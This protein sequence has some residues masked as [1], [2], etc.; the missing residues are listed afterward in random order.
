MTDSQSPAVPEFDLADRMRKS[1]RTSGTSV[2]AMA[3]HLDVSRETVST[4]IN[5]RHAPSTA[6]LRVWAEHTGVPYEW[7]R[8][9]RIRAA[10]PAVASHPHRRRTDRHLA[11]AS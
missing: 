8:W 5:G 7:L 4:W 2:Q 3:T 10:V 11:V 9:G 6:A 1:L